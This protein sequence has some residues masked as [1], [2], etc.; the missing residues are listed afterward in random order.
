MFVIKTKMIKDE[1]G[2]CVKVNARA[3]RAIHGVPEDFEAEI[4]YPGYV[5]D[6][7]DMTFTAHEDAMLFFMRTLGVKYPFVKD[8][9][10]RFVYGMV[11]ESGEMCWIP[12]VGRMN[13]YTITKKQYG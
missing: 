4:N 1:E 3:A 6:T 11:P 5:H 13:T 12:V 8:E 7:D 9:F 10:R 2:K